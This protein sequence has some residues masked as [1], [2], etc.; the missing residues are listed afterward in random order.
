[1]SDRDILSNLVLSPYIFMATSLIGK[2]RRVGSNQFRHVFSVLGILLDYKYFSNPV[3]LKAS[4]I[5]DLLEDI[6]S[7]DIKELRSID[8]DADS[9]VDLVLEVTRQINETKEEYLKRILDEGSINA[10]ILTAANYVSIL[11]DLDND[12]FTKKALEKYITLVKKYVLPMAVQIN[13]NMA[14]EL[15]GLLRKRQAMF[16]LPEK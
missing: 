2:N 5:H 8:Q 14:Q 13:T 1:M 6:P 7:T 12:M 10:K 3:L 11:T 15:D 4:V 9:V 16:Q